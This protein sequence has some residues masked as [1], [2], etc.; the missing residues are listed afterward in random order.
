MALTSRRVPESVARKCKEEKANAF[1]KPWNLLYKKG[2]FP[3]L[4]RGE[5]N[6]GHWSRPHSAQDA[7]LG[8]NTMTRPCA[9]FVAERRPANAPCVGEVV[10]GLQATNDMQKAEQC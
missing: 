9:S 1:S 3:W 8:P 10:G 4:G 6:S 2:N 5:K 7:F